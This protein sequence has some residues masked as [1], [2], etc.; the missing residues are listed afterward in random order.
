MLGGGLIQWKKESI[1]YTFNTLAFFFKII[2]MANYP[3]EKCFSH[4][5]TYISFYC[6]GR[7]ALYW[8]KDKP[9]F[10]Q[11][12]V[13]L[14]LFMPL[15][16]P[17]RHFCVSPI[18]PL[19]IIII[20]YY[21]LSHLDFLASGEANLL[22]EDLDLVSLVPLQLDHLSVLWMLYYSTIAS[23]LLQQTQKIINISIFRQNV[24]LIHIEYR[25][26]C[27]MICICIA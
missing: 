18:L 15:S 2:F 13:F 25:F 23:K 22:D 11:I 21:Y 16:W 24:S 27:I 19:C 14:T 12:S 4:T 3:F 8:S 26:M 17:G 7:Y 20:D 10:L 1:P 9:G 6:L 5:K